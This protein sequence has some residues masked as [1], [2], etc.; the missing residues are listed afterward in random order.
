M[1]APPR[2]RHPQVPPDPGGDRQLGV[3]VDAHRGNTRHD[4]TCGPQYAPGCVRPSGQE[5]CIYVSAAHEGRRFE[6]CGGLEAHP[7]AWEIVESDG[8]PASH[9]VLNAGILRSDNGQRQHLRARGVHDYNG[10]S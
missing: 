3:P 5:A 9:G 4:A 1:A 7:D 8:P 6:R 2:V 10:L